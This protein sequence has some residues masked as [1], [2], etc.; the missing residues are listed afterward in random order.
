MYSLISDGFKKLEPTA[1]TPEKFAEYAMAQ[2]IEGVRINSIGET[3]ND[4]KT[5]SVDYDVEFTVNGQAVPFS[6]TFTLKYR[7]DD[8]TPGWKLIHPYGKNIDT[9]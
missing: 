7:K 8:K 1:N 4:G 2:G 5:A 3:S 6:G 9:S